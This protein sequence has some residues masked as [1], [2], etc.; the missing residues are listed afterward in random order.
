DQCAFCGTVLM[1]VSCPRCFGKAFVGTKH[2]QHCGAP[3]T[4]GA[5]D[6][7]AASQRACPRCSIVHQEPVQLVAHLVDDTLLDH[8]PKCDGMWIDVDALEK[9]VADRDH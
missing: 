6:L 1:V 3:V 7:D 2:C 5:R 9:I 4:E 8:C